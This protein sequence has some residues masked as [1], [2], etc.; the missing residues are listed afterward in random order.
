MPPDS[1]FFINPA[2][3]ALCNDQGEIFNRLVAEF[4]ERL[5]IPGP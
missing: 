4:L 3:R 2:V 1:R 5:E